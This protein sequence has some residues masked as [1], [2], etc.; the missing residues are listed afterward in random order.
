MNVTL[1]PVDDNTVVNIKRIDNSNA[2]VT[3]VGTI[4][5][6]TNPTID[7][8]ENYRLIAKNSQWYVL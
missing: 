4:D 3:I 7:S 8:M 5:N 6:E 2:V 1:L